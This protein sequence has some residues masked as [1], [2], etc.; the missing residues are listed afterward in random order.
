MNMQATVAPAAVRGSQALSRLLE[1]GDVHR[2][3][4][5][6][7][8]AGEQAAIMRA[9]GR[10]VVTVSLESPA[11]YVGDYQ[12]ADFPGSFDAVW[13]S[14]V[15]EHQPNVNMFLR[16]CFS[17]LRDDGVLAVTVPPMKDEIVGGH[18][19]VWNAGLLLYNLILAGFDC[20]NARVSAPYSSGPGYPPY[21]ISVIVRK[22]RADLPMLRCDAGDIERLA[23]FFPCP[24]RQGFDGRLPEINW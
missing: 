20:R 8:G 9:A 23:E 21:N 4:D 1:Y 15:L 12:T 11:D 16:T 3:L 17:D 18:L 10:D 5:V 13:V 24:A 22:R 7:S 2:I 6:G 14:H 19:T